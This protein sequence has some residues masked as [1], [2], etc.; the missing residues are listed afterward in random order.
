MDLKNSSEK[1]FPS[2]KLGQNFLK[3]ANILKKICRSANLK[4]DDILVEIGP[5]F[6]S[7]T[8]LLLKEV[9]FIYAIEK[10][11]RLAK[12]LSSNYI[13]NN[14]I[15]I[16]ND[17]ILNIK[18][19][20]FYNT[21]LL[22]VVANLPYN[23]S[24]P[25]LF[26]LIEEKNIFSSIVIMIQK[27]VG[28]RIVASSSTKNYG[29]LSIMMQTH[30]NCKILFKVS[31]NAFYPKPKVESVVIELFPNYKFEKDIKNL[32]T[33]EKTVRAAFS[34]RR[35]MLGNALSNHFPKEQINEALIKSKINNTL[36]AENLTINEFINLSNSL[37]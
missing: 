6:G 11:T 32:D 4:P 1:F 3:D 31:P 15:E 12:N 25:I 14:K 2:K 8:D 17:D 22:K 18:L 24:T 30:F 13:N 27:E 35:K 37:S 19:R 34:S 26:K 33:F 23:I 20:S 28:D 10:D 29:S 21:K 36:R 5:G 9:S 7:L 16:I